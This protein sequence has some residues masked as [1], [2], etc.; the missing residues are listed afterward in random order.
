MSL[1]LEF[2]SNQIDESNQHREK[3]DEE[4]FSIIRGFSR[5]DTLEKSESTCDK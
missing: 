3:Q 1:N 5:C 2:D 4:K